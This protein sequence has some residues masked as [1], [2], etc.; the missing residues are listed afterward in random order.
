MIRL[1]AV[2]DV[3]CGTDVR[4]QI[5]SQFASVPDHVDALL[6]AGD[7]TRLGLP[8]EAE[9]RI[10]ARYPIERSTPVTGLRTQELAD[11]L[12]GRPIPTSRR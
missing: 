6:L 3:H 11:P 1:A 7:L 2:G 4:A 12:A 9:V 5:R 10:A 8:E